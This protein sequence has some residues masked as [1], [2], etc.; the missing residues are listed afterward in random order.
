MNSYQ[1]TQ[2]SPLHLLLYVPAVYMFFV[3]WQLRHDTPP[4]I[5]VLLFGLVLIFLALSF[6]SLTVSDDEGELEVSYGPNNLFGTRIPYAD[7]TDVEVGK[8]SVIDG[9]GI[10]FI[11]FRGWTVNLWG[12]EC[13]VI[14]RGDKTIR[15]GTDDSVNLCK[16]LQKRCGASNN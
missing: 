15:I 12:F 7:I 9:W 13:V 10:H 11:P 8:T 14:K 5:G 16:F 3:A 1:H 4:S 2:R 6:Q